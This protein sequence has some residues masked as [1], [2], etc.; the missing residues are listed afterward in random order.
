MR[1]AARQLT[2]AFEFLGLHQLFFERHAI[3]DVFNGDFGAFRVAVGIHG[4]ARVEPHGD[5]FSVAAFPLD[6]GV[7]AAIALIFRGDLGLFG[8]IA[9]KFARV[10]PTGHEFGGGI[11]SRACRPARDSRRAAFPVRRADPEDAVESVI[12]QAAVGE[13]RYRGGPFRR[14]C[15]R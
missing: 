10:E 6:R 14:A 3:G 11:H 8:W 5:E 9:E 4:H 15:V 1:N 7:Q 2:D 12:D 13:L